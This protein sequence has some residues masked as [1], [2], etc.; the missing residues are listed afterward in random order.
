M[1]KIS[2]G[3]MFVSSVFG[4]VIRRHLART[5]AYNGSVRHPA[6]RVMP[7]P[8]SQVPPELMQQLHDATERFHAAMQELERWMSAS[9]YRHQE[10]VAA[11][12]EELRQA[13]HAIEQIE[14]RIKQ[15]LSPER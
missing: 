14:D 11:A 8:A 1:T 10:R 6:D 12:E 9:E 13:E 4:I 7:A 15:V 5:G 2:H 3:G